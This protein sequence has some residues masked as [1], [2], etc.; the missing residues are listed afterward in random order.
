MDGQPDLGCATRGGH[1]LARERCVGDID[2][3]GE[4][5]WDRTIDLLIKSQLLYR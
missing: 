5:G 1:S 3:I 2:F 4:P